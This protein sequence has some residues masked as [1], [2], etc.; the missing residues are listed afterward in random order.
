MRFLA[1]ACVA[2]RVA[3][4]LREQGHDAVHVRELGLQHL[5]DPEVFALAAREQRVVLTFDLDFGEIVALS[6]RRGSGVVVMRLRDTTT[7]H[8]VARLQDVLAA[9]S[10]ALAAGAIVVVEKSRHRVRFWPPRD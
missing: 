4:W 2:V 7:R 9:V 6:G 5:A 1:D 8:V 3:A 10:D